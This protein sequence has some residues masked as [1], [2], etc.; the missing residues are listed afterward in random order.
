ME[1]QTKVILYMDE[2]DVQKF[3]LSIQFL[4]DDGFYYIN[5]INTNDYAM[6]M[7]LTIFYGILFVISQLVVDIAYVLV[8][9]RIRI[10]SNN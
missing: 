10:A 5:S 2:P 9:P 6:T 3:L 1:L 7:G 8:D 4:Q